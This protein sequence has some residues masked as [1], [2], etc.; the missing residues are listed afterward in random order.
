MFIILL[1]LSLL[2]QA[3]TIPLGSLTNTTISRSVLVERQINCDCSDIIRRTLLDIVRSCLFTIA[4][5]VYRAIHQNIP[6]PEATWL[7]RM[8]ERIKITFLALLAPEIMVWWSMKHEVSPSSLARDKLTSDNTGWTLTHGHFVEMGGFVRK[9]NRNVLLPEDFLAA[10]T[11]GHLDIDALRKVSEKEI[12]DHS[13][14]DML[15]KGLVAMQ[16]TWF[17]CECVTRWVLTS[18]I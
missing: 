12:Q 11:E 18:A 9:D 2:R 7:E 3:A 1:L 13:K 14:G 8:W 6:D 5:C 4:A 16:T 17:V 15:S 10:F